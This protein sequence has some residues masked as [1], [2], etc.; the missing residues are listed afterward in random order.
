MYEVVHPC[1]MIL[2]LY[3]EL[4]LCSH[5]LLFPPANANHFGL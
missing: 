2:F 5:V 1:S 3:H 4:S